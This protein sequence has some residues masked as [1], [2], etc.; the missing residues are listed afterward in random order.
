M[1]LNINKIILTTLIF[2]LV[3]N[4]FLL[5]DFQAFYIRAFLAFLFII[6]VPGLLLMLILKIREVKF[7]EYLVYTIGLSIAFIMF[8]GLAVNWTLPALEITD[9][10][11]SLYPI[12]L[13]FD[14]F[15]LVM[16]FFAYKRNKD[17]E[18]TPKLPKLDTL[19][20]I[21]FI[22]P[23]IFPVLSILGALILNNFGPNYLTMIMLG[24]IAVYVFM[25]VL[26]RKRLN[27]NIYPWALFLIGL[28]LLLMTSARGNYVTGSDMYVE[29]QI[30]NIA[31]HNAFWSLSNLNHAYNAMLSVNILPAMLKLFSKI[32]IAD[33]FKFGYQ[34]IFAL[35]P[36]IV[37]ILS[38]KRA[39]SLFAMISSFIFISF[40]SF[41][42]GMPNY[43]RM[44]IALLFFSLMFLVFFSK[45]ININI[46][47]VLFIIF[48]FS[49]IVSHYSTS[50][51][52]L[53]LFTLTYILTLVYKFWKNH[54]IRKFKPKENDIRFSFLTSG[55]IIIILIFGFLWYSQVTPTSD[56]LYD[57]AYKSFSNIGKIFNEETRV[58]NVPI[59]NTIKSTDYNKLLE[60]YNQDIVNSSNSEYSLLS[61]IPPSIN[62][63]GPKT[64][65]I[66][67]RRLF[68]FTYYLRESLKL[69]MGI[70]ILLGVIITLF[71]N[72]E[73]DYKISLIISL[74][75]FV[76]VVIMP[77]ASVIYS[78]DRLYQQVL[79]LLSVSSVYGAN[80]LF[81]W[82]K[83]NKRVI[84]LIIIFLFY[85]IFYVGIPFQL[86]GGY[87]SPIQLNN[88]GDYY[89]K[90]VL[91]R[92][93]IF[94][95]KWLYLEY[96]N[97][98]VIF[99]D[100]YAQ[101]RFNADKKIDHIS[102][103]FVP[104]IITYKSYVYLTFNNIHSKRFF[105]LYNG[106]LVSFTFQTNFIEDNKN[107]IY[108]NGGSDIYK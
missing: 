27:E 36:L 85:F 61:A 18:Y 91:H 22:I 64:I 23:L 102:Y 11:L 104:A 88:I 28:S 42:S 101:Q 84:I 2:L 83:E 13:C 33:I 71:K 66:K 37:F 1:K 20:R 52:T 90:N 93:D 12:L 30:A 34:T 31:E 49:M 81:S 62:F 16:G 25:L 105:A 65:P 97:Q 108:N 53:A 87:D 94:S 44:E 17:L 58:D 68:M 96:N 74:T 63:L 43:M 26:L 9:N 69:L 73:V 75:L 47:K 29:F 10:P 76:L 38:K 48:G 100:R 14:I 106:K 54:K 107:K 70:L 55:L 56:G 59:L 3:I 19:N 7:W 6:L 80:L 92:A 103:K 78:M 98:D 89:D 4:I 5:T 99:S 45:E 86:I 51:I 8:A 35:V 46:K 79:I 57:F 41:L 95:T 60:N 15:L 40:P 39:G 67:D 72:V 21:F 82:T 77:F 50:Y 32:G 24:G